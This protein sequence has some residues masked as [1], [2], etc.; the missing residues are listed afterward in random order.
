MKRFLGIAA[1]TVLGI[2]LVF[3]P[4][5]D[6]V[7]AQATAG[8]TKVNAS[9]VSGTSFTSSTLVNGAAYNVEVTAVNAAGE[10]GPS[11]IL[12]GTVPA[13]GTHTFTLSWQAS[14]GAVSYNIYD[15][16]VTAANPPVA[17]SLTIN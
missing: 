3:G 11:N 13:S 14:A 8:F 17:T 10:S 16:V 5:P 6:K 7:F 9:P 15:Q 12:T 1:C 2:L 4:R